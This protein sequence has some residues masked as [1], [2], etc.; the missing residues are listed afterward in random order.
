MN[1]I[2]NINTTKLLLDKYSLSAKISL[3]QNFLVDEKI[4]DKIVSSIDYN[5]DVAIIEI[6][7]G[8]GAITEKLLDKTQKLVSIEIDQNMV[9]ILNDIF[10][11]RENFT[12]I[13]EDILKFDLDSLIT[14][15]KKDY[16]K[17]Y[18]IANLPYYISSDILLKLFALEQQL[19]SIMIMV[20]SE[21]KERL[22]SKHNT[23]D[24]RPVTVVAK[25]F[26]KQKLSFNISKNVFYPK[27]NITSSIV[28]MDKKENTLNKKDEYISFVQLCF[29]QKRKTLYNNLRE[30]LSEEFIKK[31]FS[32]AKINEKSRPAEL[33]IADYIRLFEVYYEEKILC[34]T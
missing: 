21:F 10:P 7:P 3:G 6:G 19:D 31:I 30:E 26:Y 22:F 16:K 20:Q 34:Q 33:D 9:K 25:S 29:R 18:L 15:L 14:D 17:V 24:Y 32:L 13:N 27:P 23:K 2:A 1:N 4:V 28:L 11:N 12:L 5:D 8:L